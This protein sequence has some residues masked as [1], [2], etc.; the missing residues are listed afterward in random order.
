MS[1]MFIST[2]H[3]AHVHQLVQHELHIELYHLK[4]IIM[5]MCMSYIFISTQH[6]AHVHQLAQ[7]RSYTSYPNH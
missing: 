7:H 5:H 2:Q 1:Y 3:Y 4:I 6:Y